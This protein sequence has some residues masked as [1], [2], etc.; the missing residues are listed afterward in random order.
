MITLNEIFDDLTYGELAQLYVGGAESDGIPIAEYPKV[1]SAVNLAL[2]ALYSRFPLNEKEVDIQQY[3]SITEYHLDVKYAVSNTGSTEP[4]KYIIDTV[5]D[6][7]LDDLI[8]ITAAY[9]EVGNEVPLNDEDSVN[10]TDGKTNSWFTPSYDSIQIPTP[11]STNKCSFVYRAKHVKI[12]LNTSD[13]PSVEVLIPESLREALLSYVG[14]RIY[15]ARG[16]ESALGLSQAL[17]S[18]YEGICVQVEQKNLLLN[19]SSNTNTKLE[20]NGWV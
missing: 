19:G 4:I 20:N 17:Y 14:A 15:S 6:P 9:D 13:I 16:N 12:P 3:D 2:T 18:K 10:I 5:E 1:I 7:F 8:R 11:V